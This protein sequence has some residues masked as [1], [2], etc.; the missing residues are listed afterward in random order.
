MAIAVYGTVDSP[1]GGT[2]QKYMFWCTISKVWEWPNQHAKTGFQNFLDSIFEFDWFLPKTSTLW[3]FSNVEQDLLSRK[4][5][6]SIFVKKWVWNLLQQGPTCL[7]ASLSFWKASQTVS[8]CLLVFCWNSES[9]SHWD[10]SS[11]KYIFHQEFA[12]LHSH[13][14]P[15]KW[16]LEIRKVLPCFF[17]D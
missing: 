3:S 4:L 11:W 6:I 2:Y 16:K 17:L 1:S 8:G 15:K 5:N 12:P 7:P 10:I 13:L 9:P 14:H